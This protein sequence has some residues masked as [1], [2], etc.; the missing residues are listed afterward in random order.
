MIIV[1][2][3]RSGDKDKVT[4]PV[5]VVKGVGLVADK[6]VAVDNKVETEKTVLAIQILRV[7]VVN[8]PISWQLTWNI[9]NNFGHRSKINF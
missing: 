4:F 1:V 8:V 9:S 6:Q 7:K 5:E 2:V 3:S